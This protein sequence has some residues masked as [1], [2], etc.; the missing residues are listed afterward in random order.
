VTSLSQTA[1]CSV[2]TESIKQQT[3]DSD[4]ENQELKNKNQA[5][6][7]NSDGNSFAEESTKQ[8]HISENHVEQLFNSVSSSFVYVKNNFIFA[9]L[10]SIFFFNYMFE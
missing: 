5:I 1:K 7:L 10:I 2:N 6:E 8:V 4:I 3:A 9:F